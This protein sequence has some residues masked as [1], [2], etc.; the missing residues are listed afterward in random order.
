MVL[1][2]AVALLAVVCLLGGDSPA[3][4]V[5]PIKIVALGDSLT[6]G[7][8]LATDEAFPARLERALK[9][10]GHAVEIVNAGVSGDTAAGGLVRLDW[11]VPKDADGVILALGANDMLRGFDPKLTQK[12]LDTILGRLAERRI[13][14][15]LAGMRAMPNLGADFG[16]GF[17]AIYKE[18]AAKHRVVFYPF[19]LEGVAGIA[20]LN[21]PDGVHPSAAGVDR[22]VA[23]ILPKA[24]ELIGRI[25]KQQ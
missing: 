10:R 7:Y 13:E 16:E 18:L 17:E 14:V 25:Q 21:L 2:Q 5:K 6:A 3:A 19:F 4:T 20:R 9:G 22:M 12:T 8:G 1:V 15:L 23:G 24:E 11:S